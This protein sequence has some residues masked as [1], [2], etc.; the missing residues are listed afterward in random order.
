MESEVRAVC[1]GLSFPSN[2]DTW[3]WEQPRCRLLLGSRKW[4]SRADRKC[5]TV[6]RSD[7]PRGLGPQSVRLC[8]GRPSLSVLFFIYSCSPAQLQ[9]RSWK[10]ERSVGAARL[11]CRRREAARLR[12]W[13]WRSCPGCR[14]R[15]RTA[16]SERGTWL[17]HLG[18]ASSGHPVHRAIFHTSCSH[19]LLFFFFLALVYLSHYIFYLFFL[20]IPWKVTFVLSPAVSSV[21]RTSAGAEWVFSKYLLGECL[22]WSL[23]LTGTS[24]GSDQKALFLAVLTTS[25]PAKIHGNARRQRRCPKVRDRKTV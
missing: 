23:H 20:F 8:V 25:S 11:R 5:E 15:R 9:L 4:T 10:G 13:G 16:P 1:C 24:C 6:S 7:F 22:G 19:L 21:S 12:C 3:P 14:V 18:G 17:C 2:A